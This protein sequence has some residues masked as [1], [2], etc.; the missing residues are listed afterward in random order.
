[1]LGNNT[2]LLELAMDLAKPS[3]R[4]DSTYVVFYLII[5]VSTLLSVVGT[6]TPL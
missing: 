6:S 2:V 3:E 1:M 5:M 4:C